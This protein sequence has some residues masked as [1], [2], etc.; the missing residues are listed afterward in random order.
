MSLITYLKDTQGE[1][2]HVSW[3][4][5]AQSI[6]FTIVVVLISVFVSFFLGFFDYLFKLVI[7]KFVL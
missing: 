1:L 2:K 3:P 7:E 6:A 4:T 5:R